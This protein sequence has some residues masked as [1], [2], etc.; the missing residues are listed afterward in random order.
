MRDPDGLALEI[1]VADH[2]ADD[3]ELLEILLTKQCEVGANRVEQ[4]GDDRRDAV[5]MAGPRLALPPLRQTGD[6]YRSRE[7]FRVD[8]LD[9]R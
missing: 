7:S 3:R 6:A 5:E 4:F 9:A 1:E 2:L 8:V